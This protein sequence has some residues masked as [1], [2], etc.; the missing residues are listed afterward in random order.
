MID[1]HPIR[2][3]FNLKLDDTNELTLFHKIILLNL[4]SMF[5]STVDYFSNK[6]KEEVGI[7]NSKSSNSPINSR[8]SNNNPNV[9][10]YQLEE[11]KTNDTDEIGELSLIKLLSLKDKDGNTPMLFA[12]YKGNI[13]IIKKL[14]EI[15]I[16][17]DI[18][19]KAGLDI[20][21]MAAQNDNANVIIYFK[22]KYN[23]DIF[24]SDI[25]G[26]NSIHWASSN[27]AKM[28]LGYLLYYID[29][30][31]KNIINAVNKSGQTALHLTILTNESITIIKKLIKKGINTHI[32]DNSGLTVYD[33]A[34]NNKKNDI[35]KVLIDYSTS[36][37]FGIN[38]HINDFKNKYFKFALFISLFTLL[39]YGTIAHLLPYLGENLGNQFMLKSL[40]N[41]LSVL[42]VC[43]FIYIVNSNPGIITD[44]KNE[45]LLELVSENKSIKRLCPYCMV[46]QKNYTKHCFLCNRCIEIYDHHC[47]WINN[48]IGAGNKKKFITFLCFLLGI[49]I[50]EYFI[51]LQTLVLPMKE[52]YMKKGYIMSIYY[53][54]IIIAGL[55]CLTSLF[56]FFPVAY[57]IYNQVK[58]ECPP[59]P[60]KNEVKE[61]YEEL[62]EINDGNNMVNHLQIKED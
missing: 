55:I 42:F 56:F 13:D 23:Y 49:I 52:K 16:K 40:F 36:N 30:K 18:K 14:I 11:K 38:Y 10:L 50:L 47:H 25:Q 34:K 17:Y 53:Y 60:K 7:F 43:F 32:K 3:Y 21:H 6:F 44:K 1:S 62:K 5:N 20:I 57:I 54:K 24:Q 37:C 27:C 31:N 51:S 33:I 61:Y 26:N 8:E 4:T 48:C 59:K 35:N 45:S 19:N 12:A 22:E 9:C 2:Y 41:V 28:A 46:D 39:F 58:N 15:G 29:E